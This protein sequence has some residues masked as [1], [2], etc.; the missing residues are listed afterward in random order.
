MMREQITANF[1]RATT[2][3]SIF[4]QVSKDLVV[5]CNCNYAVYDKTGAMTDKG[6]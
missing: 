5:E 1:S 6:M 2:A 4:E 3:D